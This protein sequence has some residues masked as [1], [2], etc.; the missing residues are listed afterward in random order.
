MENTVKHH[1]YLDKF[2]MGSIYV[3]KHIILVKTPE[4]QIPSSWS[5][6]Q[7]CLHA[8]VIIIIIIII[9]INVQSTTRFLM[10]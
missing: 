6:V 3:I 5:H 2:V 8:S 1:I 9:I 7:A 4:I 10:T